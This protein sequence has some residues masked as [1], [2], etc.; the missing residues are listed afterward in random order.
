DP[1]VP[2]AEVARIEERLRM[3]GTRFEVVTYSTVRP[4]FPFEGRDAHAPLEAADAWRRL[5]RMFDE[6]LGR[7][8]ST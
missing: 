2:A 8:G 7:P 4:G 3:L 1:T 5:R 6:E